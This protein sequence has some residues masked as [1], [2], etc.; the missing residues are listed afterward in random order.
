LNL[1]IDVVIP[2]YQGWE[3]T[4]SCLHHLALQTVPHTVILSDNASTDGTPENVRASFPDV[5][6]V[7]TGGN[8]GFPVACNRG[9]EAGW[10]DVV[11][12]LNNDVDVRPDFLERLVE[13]L[14]ADD[15][16]GSVAALLVR[17]GERLIDSIGLAA[18]AT[19][20]AFPRLRGR[21]A[22]DAHSKRPLLAGPSGGAAAYRRKAWEQAGGL[23]EAVFSYMEDLDLALRLLTAGWGPAAA[24]DA[25]GVHLGSASMGHRSAQQR[26]Q[27]AFSRGYFLRRY[28][29]LRS[30]A[31]LRALA[32]EAVVVGGD[33]ALSRDIVALRGRLAGW[34]AAAGRP[35]HPRP[36]AEALDGGIGFFDSLRRRRATYAAT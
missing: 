29:V 2:T 12:L 25:V 3:L 31:F 13:P 7:E 6:L 1:S 19:L 33:A 14:E 10:S 9:A 22:E 17:P 28:G 15:R 18:D 32:T 4:E 36:P 26:R 20:A 21:P 16:V 8:L 24:P 5:R 11:V 23:D 27:L 30:R 34:R 35:R